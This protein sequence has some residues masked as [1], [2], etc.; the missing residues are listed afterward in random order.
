MN[1]EWV[2]TEE[3]SVL[4]SGSSTSRSDPL[5]LGRKE[6][7]LR[8]AATGQRDSRIVELWNYGIS[9]PAFLDANS[10][11]FHHHHMQPSTVQYLIKERGPHIHDQ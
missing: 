6:S 4:F 10:I 11:R 8:G 1:N 5:A 3:V 9:S 2:R 7:G